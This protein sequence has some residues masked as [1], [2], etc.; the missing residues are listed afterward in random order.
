M[1]IRPSSPMAEW[2]FSEYRTALYH[3]PYLPWT[4]L[5]S[6]PFYLLA[7]AFYDQ[8]IVYLILIVT[9]LVLA[10]RLVHGSRARLALVAN[11][12]ETVLAT[13]N[14]IAGKVG[15]AAKRQPRQQA[16]VRQSKK[17]LD[18]LPG[19]P[20]LKRSIENLQ[21]RLNGG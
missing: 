2:G 4:F 6:I 11:Q 15:P 1:T 21:R 17:L 9:A 7:G 5:F 20:G 3:Y 12:P 10:P 13:L 14:E 16:V 8:R 18:A 19:N